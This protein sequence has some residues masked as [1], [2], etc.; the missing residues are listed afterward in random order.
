MATVKSTSSVATEDSG[1]NSSI[2]KHNKFLMVD[3][4]PLLSYYVPATRYSVNFR[5]NLID[6]RIIAAKTKAN[7]YD[8]HEIILKSD[9]MLSDRITN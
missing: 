5:E 2:N 1:Q 3:G 4:L 6:E 9:S 7:T 8:M